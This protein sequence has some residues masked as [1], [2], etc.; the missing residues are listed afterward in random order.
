ML[1]PNSE[2]KCYDALFRVID[3][4]Q[5]HYRCAKAERIPVVCSTALAA[6]SIKPL[7]LWNQDFGPNLRDSNL[8]GFDALGARADALGRRSEEDREIATTA[9]DL[10]RF[11]DSRKI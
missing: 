11:L 6:T 1:R 10:L 7:R 5:F 8:V 9:D 2:G 4:L 3:G